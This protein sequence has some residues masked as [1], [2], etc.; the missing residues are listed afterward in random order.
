MSN[1]ITVEWWRRS[2]EDRPI[3]L[4]GSLGKNNNE[5]TSKDNQKYISFQSLEE[6]GLK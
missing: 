5:I 2:V 6:T 1:V 3:K 4:Q